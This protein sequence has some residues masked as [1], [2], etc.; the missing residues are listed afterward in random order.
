MKKALFAGTFDPVTVGHENIIKR[1]N[2]IFDKVYVAVCINPDK[3]AYFT[4]EERLEMLKRA[5]SGLSNVEVYYHTGLLVDFMRDN[6]IKYNIRGIRTVKD[7][8][9]EEGMRVLN[10]EAYPEMKTLYFPSDKGFIEVSSTAVREKI[11]KGEDLT[12]LL[13]PVVKEIAV[14]SISKRK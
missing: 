14:N 8:I 2:E 3:H 7:F 6:G 12:A 1:C 9:Y 4:V 13:S 5:V 10:E 11:L